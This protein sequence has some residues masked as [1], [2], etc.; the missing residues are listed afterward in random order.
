[1]SDILDIVGASGT[2]YRFRRAN[3]DDLPATAGNVVVVTG[4][5][6]KPRI[7]LCGAA[8]SLMRAAPTLKE[9][10]AGVRGARVFIRLNV[11]RAAREA[12]H[13]DIV[14]AV[15]PDQAYDDLG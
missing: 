7:H 3:L 13:A 2:P 11:A 15:Q 9:A 6:S 5:P 12:E 14:A 8:R 10:L 4:G 1:V